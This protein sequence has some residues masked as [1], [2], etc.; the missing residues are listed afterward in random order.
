MAKK[1]FNPD[2]YVDENDPLYDPM[3]EIRAGMNAVLHGGPSTYKGKKIRG[4][5]I[6]DEDEFLKQNPGIEPYENIVVETIGEW[7]ETPDDVDD[8][9]QPLEPCTVKLP[10][11]QKINAMYM[12]NDIFYF[13]G[14]PVFFDGPIPLFPVSMGNGS[15]YMDGDINE[16]D[17]EYGVHF[18]KV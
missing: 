4:L 1:Q 15:A 5:Y 11:G 3:D 13:G 12:G 7:W 16:N 6:K 2:D 14:G 10:P 9:G 17:F 8:D 18:K